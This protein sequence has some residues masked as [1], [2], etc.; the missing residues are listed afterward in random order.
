MNEKNLRIIGVLALSF[1]VILLHLKLFRFAE[2]V[3]HGALRKLICLGRVVSVDTSENVDQILTF[4]I[5]SGQFR[6]ETVRVDNIWIGRKFSDRTIKKSDVLF[7]EIPLR[8]QNQTKIDE[9]RM[10]SYFRTPFLLY[11]AWLL[12]TLIILVAGM[13]GI[14][15][16]LTLFFTGLSVLYILV[17]LMVRGYNPITVALGIAA[18]LTVVTFVTI[19]GLSF[20]VISGVLGT[21]GGL[22]AVGVLSLISQKV[23]VLTGLA[24][25]FGFLELGIALWRTETSHGWN[26]AGILSAGIILGAV[27]AMMDVGMSIS[28]SVHEVKQVN[29][30]ITVRQAIRAGLNV[31]R[32]IM[33]TMADT[34]IFA[35]LGAHL[36]TMLLPTIEFPEVG[37]LYPF[38]RLAND[39]AT[40]VAIIQAIVGTI[41]LVLTVPIAAT[42][43]GF[44]TK[45]RTVQLTDIHADAPSAEELEE[46]LYTDKPGNKGRF[47]VSIAMIAVLLGTVVIYQRLNNTSATIAEQRDENGN[48]ISKSEYAKGKVLSL[49]ES[50]AKFLFESGLEYTNNLDNREIPNGLRAEFESNGITLSQNVNVEIKTW[51]DSRW[52]ITDR[53]REQTYAARRFGESL[54]IY[55]AN[56]EHHIL[57]IEMLSGLYDGQRLVL[58]NIVNHNMPLLSIPATPGDIVL[59]RVGGTPEQISLVNILQEYGRDGFLVLMLGLMFMLIIVVGRIEGVRTAGAMII[60]GIIIYFFM[61]PLITGGRHAVFVVTL[62]SGMVAF[63]SLVFV[64]G[65]SRKTFS[66]VL[67]TMGGILVSGMIVMFAQKYLHFSGLENAMSA[68]IVEAM[69]TPPFDFSQL[70]V[71]GMLMGVLGVAVDGAIE[72]SSSMEEIRRANPN[73]PTWRLAASGMNVGTDILGT[74]VNTLVFAYLG[75]RLLLVLAVTA[76]NVDLF[77][78]PPVELLSVGVVAAEIVRLLAGT[79]GLVLAIPMT[80]LIAA[81]WNSKA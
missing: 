72:V 67:G 30:N 62:T 29:P 80:A 68:D 23:M 78:S 40:S 65:P 39:E 7:L 64:I 54:K 74:M 28:S 81:L 12:G 60:S 13:K 66:A 58:R 2:V 22:A 63:V 61:L 79:L 44:L 5:L 36:V 47:A 8:Y 38:L 18:L 46:L 19:T 51:K 21:L 26:F 56:T 15:A 45:Y 34:L 1:I 76:P 53:D 24:E 17:P 9:V 37:V 3:H 57:E 69:R 48:V 73:M 35:Y 27:G 41:G 6:G 55:E 16:I 4:R 71:A 14:R 31:G 32:D 10:G 25:E 50:N 49:L 59:C 70:L 42:I 11:L 20:K 52:L 77:Q 33:G 43:A 75:A